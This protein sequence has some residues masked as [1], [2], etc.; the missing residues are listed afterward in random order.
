MYQ[1]IDV[2][3]DAVN[4]SK[5]DVRIVMDEFDFYKQYKKHLNKV[6]IVSDNKF[7]KFFLD[8]FNKFS[9]TEFKTYEGDRLE[10]ARDWIFP[11][12]L[13]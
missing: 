9:D 1:N 8:K 2:L 12:R 4:V 5:Y 13:P 7:Q 3:I 6:A 10:E 11:S